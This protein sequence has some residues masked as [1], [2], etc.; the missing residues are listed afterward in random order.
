MN[1]N[2]I[3]Q[4]VRKALAN[5]GDELGLEVLEGE[6]APD[7]NIVEAISSFAV[8]ELLLMTEASV[9]ELTGRYIPLADESLFDVQH[10]PLISLQKW[11]AY[12]QGL[13]IDA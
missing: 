3:E 1:Q 8:V 12:V 7:L 4:V 2:D 5:V 13:S 6:L 10:S 9:E 11:I